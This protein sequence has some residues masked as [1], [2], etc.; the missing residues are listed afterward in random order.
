MRSAIA[1]RKE[2][3]A[4]CTKIK[5]LEQEAEKAGYQQGP[6][7]K[8]EHL[9]SELYRVRITLEWVLP[10]LVRTNAKDGD[11]RTQLMGYR[12]IAAGPLHATLYP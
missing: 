9:Y 4:V 11:R 8:D 5:E 7:E 3:K 10:M 12:H 2:H 6:L 1:I